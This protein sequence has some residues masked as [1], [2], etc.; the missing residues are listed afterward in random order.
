MLGVDDGAG[1]SIY[2]R[3][4]GVEKHGEGVQRVLAVWVKY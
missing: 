3:R 2:E 4:E 1:P